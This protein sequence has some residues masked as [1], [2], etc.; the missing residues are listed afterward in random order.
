M[1]VKAKKRHRLTGEVAQEILGG[2]NGE[3]DT[4]EVLE[5]GIGNA[6]IV[7]ARGNLRVENGMIDVVERRVRGG[8]E[9]G[10]WEGYD[11]NFECD[12]LVVVPITAWLGRLDDIIHSSVKT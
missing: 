1:L 5:S 8:E 10:R 9:L 7:L 12:E 3:I 4:G 11:D 6:G 2:Y